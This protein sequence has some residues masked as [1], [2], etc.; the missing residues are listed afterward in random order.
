MDFD[1]IRQ[2]LLDLSQAY[3]PQDWWQSDNY[4]EDLVSTVLIQR[5]TERNALLA[6]DNLKDQC[7]LDTLAAMPLADLQAA[8]RPAG[9]FKAKSQTIKSLVSWL[10]EVG[11]REG[12]VDVETS[13]LRQQ[14]L[15]LKGIGPETADVLL[16]YIFGR[17]VF[18]ADEYARRLFRR[19]E[20]ADFTTY[21]Q[22][23]KALAGLVDPLTLKDCQ[24]IHAVIDEDGK[25]QRRQQRRP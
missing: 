20:L 25:A 4:V 18:V 10:L 6:L 13:E 11:G 17:K 23:A 16:L 9:F 19:W 3:G 8:I 21:D 1:S 2:Q 24:E 14:L 15:S 22:M 7:Q 12:L 5:T